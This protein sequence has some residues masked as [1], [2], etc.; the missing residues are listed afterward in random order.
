MRRKY[1]KK[2]KK[3]IILHISK[4]SYKP[5]REN[6]QTNKLK[7]KCTKFI[8]TVVKKKRTNKSKKIC[9]IFLLYRVVKSTIE[10]RCNF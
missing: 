6:K 1:W 4:I 3:N 8:I 5:V 9:L 2:K 7:K 10:M